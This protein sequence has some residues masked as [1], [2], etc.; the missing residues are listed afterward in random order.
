MTTTERYIEFLVYPGIR[1]F[2]QDLS[3]AGQIRGTMNGSTKI[4]YI[5]L[6]V[7]AF[8]LNWIWEM[9]QMFAFEV[10]PETSRFREF[11][12]CT[13]ASV[14]DALVTVGIYGLLTRINLSLNSGLFYLLA[15]LFGSLCASIFE[16]LAI[17]F[18]LWKYNRNMPIVPIIDI[19]L[20]PFV[21]LT[22][23][24]PLAIRLTQKFKDIG[25]W[26]T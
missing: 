7:I 13:L 22:L 2:E 17:W 11:F 1:H 23:L 10:K 15:A 9:A 12:F 18:E 20:L 26:K 19:G 4:F 24:V 21:Q 14:I 16:W 8:G 5:R 3:K 25:F 6:I